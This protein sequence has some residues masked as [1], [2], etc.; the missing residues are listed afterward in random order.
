MTPLTYHSSNLSLIALETM[1]LLVQ[2]QKPCKKSPEFYSKPPSKILTKLFCCH[3]HENVQK[4][5]ICK[6]NWSYYIYD[7]TIGL[8]CVKNLS[9]IY[10]LQDKSCCSTSN[11]VNHEDL[12]ASGLII[13]LRFSFLHH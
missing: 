3:L 12:K 2:I 11:A 4:I 7:G 13:Q 1:R 8:K 9:N 10:V 5:W 6:K